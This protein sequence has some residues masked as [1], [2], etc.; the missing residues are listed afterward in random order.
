[1]REPDPKGASAGEGLPRLPPGRHGLDRDFVTKNQRDR[2]TA[3]IIAVVGRRGYGVATI[4]QIC[5]EAGVSRRTFY[6]YFGGKEDCYLDALARILDYLSSE[7]SSAEEKTPDWATAVRARLAA[8]LNAFSANPDLVRF[9][10]IAP[11]RAGQALLPVYHRNVEY[12]LDL[13]RAGRP[14]ETSRTPSPVVQ[15][16]VVGGMMASV[17]LRVESEEQPRLTELLPD[18]TEFFLAQYLGQAEAVG[19]VTDLIGD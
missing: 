2:L 3:G 6:S 16:A 4:A 5:E 8:M 9:G 11:L 1:V 19:A 10:W 17:A 7:M 18:L 12:I 14:A 15:Q 13:L